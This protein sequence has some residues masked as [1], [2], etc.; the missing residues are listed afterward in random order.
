M[1]GKTMM[2]EIRELW[3]CRNLM[4]L[5][6]TSAYLTNKWYWYKQNRQNKKY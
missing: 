1:I 5:E 4:S 6:D 2:L 3:T